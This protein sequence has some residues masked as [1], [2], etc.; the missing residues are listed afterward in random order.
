MTYPSIFT[1]VSFFTDSP[2]LAS[3]PRSNHQDF[4]LP[5]KALQDYQL[6]SD[7]LFLQDQHRHESLFAGC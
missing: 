7:K 4:Q 5:Q 6:Y 3:Y 1:T 2:M